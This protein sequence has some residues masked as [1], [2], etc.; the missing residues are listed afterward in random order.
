MSKS[1]KDDSFAG[2]DDADRHRRKAKKFVTEGNEANE[3]GADGAS[4]RTSNALQTFF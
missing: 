2:L 3:G 1:I 4:I